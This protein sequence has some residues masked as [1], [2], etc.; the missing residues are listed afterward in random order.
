M[1]RLGLKPGACDTPG[2]VSDLSNTSYGII[3]RKREV[4]EN[5][6]ECPISY[7]IKSILNIVILITCGYKYYSFAI[8]NERSTAGTEESRDICNT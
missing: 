1:P 7:D 3:R 4:V 6:V 8:L 2:P 5:L